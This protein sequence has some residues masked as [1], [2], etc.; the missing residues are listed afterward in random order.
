LF[1]RA[2]SLGDVTAISNLGYMA[3]NGIGAEKNLPLAMQQ[4]EKAANGGN[5]W[6]MRRLASLLLASNAT[7]AQNWLLKAAEGGDAQAMTQLGNAFNDGRLGPR[8]P[9][10][11]RQWFDKAAERGDADAMNMLG[12]F[13]H[14]GNGVPR[15]H[16]VAR[17]W[18]QRA[19][20]RGNTQAMANLGVMYEFGQAVPQN[21]SEA[22]RLFETAATRGNTFGMLHLG[23][24]AEFGKGV[25]RDLK[26]AST[27]YAKA[28]D[29][30]NADAKWRVAIMLDRYSTNKNLS[31][32]AKT[33]LEAVRA[34]SKEAQ[35][36]MFG[37]PER[38]M[39][40]DLRAAI[41]SELASAGVYNG[42]TRGRF[43]RPVREALENYIKGPQRPSTLIGR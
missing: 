31:F 1:E 13:Y 18:Y 37:K 8:D 15:D 2:L 41:E 5:H 30:G 16:Q 3:E 6:S 20:E 7:Q 23:Q 38:N 11:A 42:P 4:Y 39:S 29:A 43:D 14:N 22:W 21:Y 26:L 35:E 36:G 28:A 33:A 40:R 34:G 32:L 12:V 17:N 19:V 24:M 25:N 27:W 10:V 9:I